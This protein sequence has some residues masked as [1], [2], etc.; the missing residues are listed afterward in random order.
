MFISPADEGAEAKWRAAMSFITSFHTLTTLEIPNNV[1]QELGTTI[2][3][4]FS[5]IQLQ[6]I[7]THK[8]LETLDISYSGTRPGSRCM[9]QSAE[10]IRSIVSALPRLRVLKIAPEEG[11]MAEAAKALA[12]CANLE[13]LTIIRGVSLPNVVLPAFLAHRSQPRDGVSRSGEFVWEEHYR[14][15]RIS[16]G[17][18]VWQISSQPG[19][20][21]SQ[22]E[23]L[24]NGQVGEARR[25][26]FVRDISGRVGD[27]DS[28]ESE[29][30]F[31]WIEAGAKDTSW[32]ANQADPSRQ[33]ETDGYWESYIPTQDTASV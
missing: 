9:L 24:T 13:S 14:L 16:N 11:Q 27:C 5:K 8:G 28:V 2:D 7:L 4:A 25:E 29:G 21:T 22:V 6:A 23:G 19:T 10:T 1:Y 18:N 32:V 26:V 12:N 3:P 31:E 20:G 17:R 33:T 15:K 30:Q